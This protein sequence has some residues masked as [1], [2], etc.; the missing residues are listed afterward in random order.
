M[1]K[2][3]QLKAVFYLLTVFPSLVLA[4]SPEA[5]LNGV[6]V[7]F[8]QGSSAKGA[9][10]DKP[11][12]VTPH[13]HNKGTEK[14][15][16]AA[17]DAPRQADGKQKDSQER[18][19][20]ITNL[21]AVNLDPHDKT[22]KITS[23]GG[24][25]L[26]F[27]TVPSKDKPFF[28]EVQLRIGVVP[29]D[30]QGQKY[31]LGAAL[32]GQREIGG[33][34]KVSYLGVIPLF[35]NDRKISYSFKRLGQDGKE[36]EF[37]TNVFVGIDETDGAQKIKAEVLSR[38]AANADFQ[39][40]ILDKSTTS[41]E[42]NN[43]NNAAD[44]DDLV[45][46]AQ[47]IEK[48]LIELEANAKNE[49]FKKLTAEAYLKVTKISQEAQKLNAEAKK[50]K[51]ETE[52]TKEEG[53]SKPQAAPAGLEQIKDRADTQK[54]LEKVITEAR[55]LIAKLMP[56][57][58]QGSMRFEE[59]MEAIRQ[60]MNTELSK[61]GLHDLGADR[62]IARDLPVF[63]EVTRALLD[64]NWVA[65]KD[66]RRPRA[67]VLGDTPFI[68]PKG[69]RPKE[70]PKKDDK[71]QAEEKKAAAKRISDMSTRA[72]SFFRVDKNDNRAVDSLAPDAVIAFN[73]AN[74]AVTGK[75]GAAS[76]SF[77]AH[78]DKTEVSVAVNSLTP[79]A[80]PKY[81]FKVTAKPK[82]EPKPK[83]DAQEKQ[84][85]TPAQAKPGQE[86]REGVIQIDCSTDLP[87]EEFEKCVL[88]N[89]KKQ[90]EAVRSKTPP[91]SQ[92]SPTAQAPASLAPGSAAKGQAG[93][94]AKLAVDEKTGCGAVGSVAQA[95]MVTKL[96]TS[97]VIPFES[98]NRLVGS[99]LGCGDG[100]G[101]QWYYTV[102][103]KGSHNHGATPVALSHRDYFCCSITD[104]NKQTCSEA[105]HK[106][107]GN[108]GACVLAK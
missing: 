66:D 44:L 84:Q 35:E 27:T 56:V 7:P 17:P 72:L 90:R 82:E 14:P 2:I 97:K 37:V 74:G 78:D 87:V 68:G 18:T 40:N 96:P 8:G 95:G 47:N 100:V 79:E 60:E 30:G 13:D 46:R 16:S 29:F 25:P 32:Y 70:Q 102:T 59:S 67:I 23:I 9:A 4:A 48:A 1:I 58:H 106:E 104:G 99:G 5:V 61:A 91:A 50:K 64:S 45:K 73:N 69:L 3:I 108:V 28:E 19:L 43:L 55:G 11:P 94:K 101:K 51:K 89:L 107:A 103:P 42:K 83:E 53:E 31:G 105:E 49:E 71:E 75:D 6:A 81:N 85:G 22:I 98:G 12:A 26:R 77:I 54:V 93:P 92:I 63:Y 34:P 36:H 15:Q 52:K 80:K 33:K 38:E 41:I 39:K 86:T 24:R 21:S 57:I 62:Y 65:V 88:E 10:A 76:D 20:N